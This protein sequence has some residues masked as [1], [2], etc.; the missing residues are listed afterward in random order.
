MSPDDLQRDIL[1]FK[2]SIKVHVSSI[3]ELKSQVTSRKSQFK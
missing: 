2:T 3:F 1:L